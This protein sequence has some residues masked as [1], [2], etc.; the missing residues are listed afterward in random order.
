[1]ADQQA[2]WYPDPS[3]DASKLRYWDGMQWGNDYMDTIV[4]TQ[5]VI[6][7]EPAALV[8]ASM[9]PTVPMQQAQPFKPTEYMQPMQPM[10][11][12]QPAQAYQTQQFPQQT[13]QYP[14]Q[15][16]QFPQQ[17]APMPGAYG[18]PQPTR[19]KGL[20]IAA[21]IIGIIGLVCAFIPFINYLG[22]ILALAGLIMGIIS[23]VMAKGGQGP[24]A[25]GLVGIITSVVAFIVAIIMTVIIAVAA[26][27]ATNTSIDINDIIA[28]IE[29]SNNS[30]DFNNN[31]NS[32]SSSNN[33]TS[34]NGG[35]VLYGDVTGQ[36]GTEYAT[37]WFTFTVNH[38]DVTP[39]IAEYA[40]AN[41]KVLLIA[42]VTITNTFGS[43]QPFGTFDWF[44][45]DDTL[46]DYISPLSPFNAELLNM[47]PDHF[48][49]DDGQT[50][51]YDVVVEFPENL[52]NP[53]FL[54]IEINEVGDAF[55]TFK[56]PIL[57]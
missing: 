46:S 24:M 39:S 7:V 23:L 42:N 50:V 38:M 27:M 14:Y 55:T 25:F 53:Y 17:A 29:S 4:A 48:D 51:T 16:Q 52:P 30:Y 2:G 43:T 18:V 56:I 28:E 57:F 35:S 47:M 6:P 5:P 1:M 8:T 9:Q 44:V 19:G 31:N 36:V 45:D 34:N 10:Q 40:A 37:R 15:T 21:M 54:Y 33:N 26:D 13:Q 12:A 22:F 20:G 49:L 32:S 41:G 3:G 11:A